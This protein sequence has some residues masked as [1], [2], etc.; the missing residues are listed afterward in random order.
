MVSNMHRLARPGNRRLTPP[1]EHQPTRFQI[2][3]QT[4]HAPPNSVPTMS[5]LSLPVELL[6][7]IIQLTLASDQQNMHEYDTADREN[8]QP[9][10]LRCTPTAATAL[11]RSCGLLRELT[12]PLMYTAVV[13]SP[14]YIRSLHE[15]LTSCAGI[16]LL[17]RHITIFV[18]DEA[19]PVAVREVLGSCVNLQHLRLN[20]SHVLGQT[21]SAGFH[22]SLFNHLSPESQVSFDLCGFMYGSLVL[23]LK[24]LSS[25]SNGFSRLET[26]R[27]HDD[28]R[29]GSAVRGWVY[30]P[31]P[32]DPDVTPHPSTQ[33]TSVHTLI[34]RSLPFS[35]LRKYAQY[36]AGDFI[37]DTMPNVGVLRLVVDGMFGQAVVHRF[38]SL[39]TNVTELT[40]DFTW[41]AAHV[42]NA[43]AALAPG[44][45]R[46]VAR[47]G[48]VCHELFENTTWEKVVHLEM[49]C[50]V[51]CYNVQRGLLRGLM[52]ALVEDRPAA[53]V[54]VVTH[55]LREL[56]AWNQ[57]G[58]VDRVA[59]LEEF[60][61]D[62]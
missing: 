8:T 62:E 57:P 35:V 23:Y 22:P 33:L 50:E 19:V 30:P 9:P 37:A 55:R 45:R 40:L 60:R 49:V 58:K 42:C 1:S 6:E 53:G 11:A 16:A 31:A 21:E 3:Y 26:I 15:Q 2:R 48:T 14:M 24:H 34:I 29:L 61:S 43:V 28:S 38:A 25:P 51:R 52:L 47:G 32:P 41:R 10:S 5:L 18:T 46:F 7:R 54:S 59:G 17:V 13:A 12:L 20:G 44:L 39:G 27:I 36:R 56:V 4:S